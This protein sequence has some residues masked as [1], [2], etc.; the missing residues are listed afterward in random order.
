LCFSQD[1]H[2]LQGEWSNELGSVLQIDSVA[3]D[4]N[5]L[6]I[7][8]S[9]TGVDGK[10]FPLQGWVNE[11]I[12]NPNQKNISFSVRWEGYGSIT[13]WTGYCHK[14]EGEDQIK[15]IWN[16]VRSGKEFDWERIITNSS[17]FKPIK[18]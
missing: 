17:I 5:I 12:E 7:Y 13:T 18:I 16:L 11:S 3:E 4:G 6:G 8:K 1:C 9:S 2:S 14:H 15:T 10:I